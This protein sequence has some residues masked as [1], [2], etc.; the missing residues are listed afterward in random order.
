MNN[1]LNI[2]CYLKTT[3]CLGIGVGSTPVG[4]ILTPKGSILPFSMI[5]VNI[6]IFNILRC[7]WMFGKRTLIFWT[8]SPSLLR[9]RT[10]ILNSYFYSF[11]QRFL[12]LPRLSILT[13]SLQISKRRLPYRRSP[14]VT[15][16]VSSVFSITL[17]RVSIA[18]L[19]SFLSFLPHSMNHI[20]RLALSMRTIV[21]PQ[22]SSGGT[23]FLTFV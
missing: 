1:P 20:K 17:Q 9:L 6:F 18:F 10:L 12:G 2:K 22:E 13:S 7:L 16:V 5:G 8:F 19:N 11:F 4:R 14:S 3:I 23:F 21:H 15:N